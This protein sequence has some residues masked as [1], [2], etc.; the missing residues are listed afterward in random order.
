[1][2]VEGP[3]YQ[4]YQFT[5]VDVKIVDAGIAGCLCR[6]K[7]F[8]DRYPVPYCTN[9]HHQVINTFAYQKMF[10]RKFVE[11]G[12]LLTLTKYRHSTTKVCYCEGL[13]AGGEYEYHIYLERNGLTDWTIY[14]HIKSYDRDVTKR[15]MV[16][17]KN[18]QHYLQQS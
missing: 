2:V 14:N 6:L 5:D 7:E 4:I 17:S 13:L 3:L 16:Y 18:R 1:M 15:K 8:F 12:Y 10:Q 9:I 11:E